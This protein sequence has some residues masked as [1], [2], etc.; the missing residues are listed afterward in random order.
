MTD[1]TDLEARFE[2]NVGLDT[3]SVRIGEVRLEDVTGNYTDEL[4]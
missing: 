2:F 4:R 1:A 3:G